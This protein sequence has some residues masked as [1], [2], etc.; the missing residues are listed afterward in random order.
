MRTCTE[1]WAGW[2]QNDEK[3][4]FEEVGIID[5]HDAD[6]QGAGVVFEELFGAMHDAGGE[7]GGAAKQGWAMLYILTISLAGGKSNLSLRT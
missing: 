4:S 7:D 1:S 2:A 3:F 6:C 5:V